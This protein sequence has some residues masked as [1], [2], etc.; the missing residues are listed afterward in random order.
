MKS[1]SATSNLRPCTYH[2]QLLFLK[3][4]Q[5]KG[6]RSSNLDST[7][8]EPVGEE[9][10]KKKKAVNKRKTKNSL[11]EDLIDLTKRVNKKIN[12]EEDERDEDR[13]FLLSLCKDFKR[14]PDSLKLDAKA[15]FINILKKYASTYNMSGPQYQ[16]TNDFRGYF[17]SNNMNFNVPS[18]SNVP[19]IQ[20][21]TFHR[22]GTSESHYSNIVSPDNCSD[23]SS[24]I[25]D[26][27]G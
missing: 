27:F 13:L 7:N 18:S 2:Q 24:Y 3:D 17:T 11:E 5:E 12:D 16:P 22:P 15:D 23:D 20:Q 21:E 8:E 14:I 4:L 6:E 10:T 19:P 26:V 1:G 25:N 9:I